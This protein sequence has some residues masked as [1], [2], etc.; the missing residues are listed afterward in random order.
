MAGWGDFFGGIG[1]ILEKIPIQGRR[2]RWRNEISKLEKEKEKI[3]DQAVTLDSVKR[4]DII[5]NRLAE[6]RRL[7]N[8][9]ESN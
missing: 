2:E 9:A 7:Q 3:V 5:N 6:L 4:M 8:N 1:K